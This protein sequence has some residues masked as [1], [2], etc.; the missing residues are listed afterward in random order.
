MD[1]MLD[2]DLVLVLDVVFVA[3]LEMLHTNIQQ[4]KTKQNKTKSKDININNKTEQ[5]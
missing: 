3:M 1:P 5:R 2:V 4:N